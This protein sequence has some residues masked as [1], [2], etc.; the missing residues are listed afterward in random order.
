MCLNF[1]TVKLMFNYHGALMTSSVVSAMIC[2]KYSITLSP[3]SLISYK[4]SSNY[5]N[6]YNNN[7]NL[8]RA[9]YF[10]GTI[11]STLNL[12]LYV[13]NYCQLHLIGDGTELQ[14]IKYLRF[15]P[16]SSSKA[17]SHTLLY[18]LFK[19]CL[20]FLSVLGLHSC[21]WAFSSC[22]ERGLLFIVIPGLLTAVASLVAEHGI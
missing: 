5:S 17:Y 11:L 14:R 1:K 9:C 13:D 19:R 15:V 2:F 7:Y 20:F 16:R 12:N 8:L 21:A 22:C 18:C 10:S 6:N 4:Y 3:K